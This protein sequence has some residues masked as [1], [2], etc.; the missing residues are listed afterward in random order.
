MFYLCMNCSIH[1]SLRVCLQ[2]S[3][4]YLTSF[5]SSSDFVPNRIET[6][7]ECMSNIIATRES[8]HWWF[9]WWSLE[10]P[11]AHRAGIIL[12]R[13]LSLLGMTSVMG[14][15][16]IAYVI[17]L[18][19][20]FPMATARGY[21]CLT[22]WHGHVYRITLPLYPPVINEGLWCFIRSLL[23]QAVG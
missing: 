5:G 23:E 13:M 3:T 14:P 17:S 8:K 9:C 6:S 15:T 19:L 16:L 10:K 12:S 1:H 18:T 21:I 20:G 2:H 11:E 7:T 22:S 4:H